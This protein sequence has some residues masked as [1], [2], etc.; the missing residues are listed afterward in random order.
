MCQIVED[1][2]K[3]ETREIAIKLIQRGENSLE[4]I[5]FC[6]NL[7]LSEVEELANSL[8]NQ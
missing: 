1:L 8:K 6:V 7:P 5:A 4:T 3:K 2:I